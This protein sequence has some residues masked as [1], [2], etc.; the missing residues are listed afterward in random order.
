MDS[1]DSLVSTYVHRAAQRFG[2]VYTAAD[3]A[4]RQPPRMLDVFS[5]TASGDE[6]LTQMTVLVDFLESPPI[7]S[8]KFVAL[9]LSGAL[10]RLVEEHG[11]ASDAYTTAASAVRAILD[12]ALAKPDVR[13]AVVTYASGERRV[14][15]AD[16][17]RAQPPPQSPIPRPTSTPASPIYSSK[18]CFTDADACGNATNACSGHGQCVAAKRA[19][20]T[21][22]VCACS[23]TKSESGR[24]TIWAGEQ[25]E[26]KDVSGY[27]FACPHDATK[28]Y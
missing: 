12:S 22:F 6:L 15:R 27:V 19:G 10:R 20:Q 16:G 13:L 11:S 1:L 9:E 26:R 3:G 28:A 4:T 18:R 14:E 25:C 8:G 17:D 5:G 7:A 21:C 23:S 24:T 2:R